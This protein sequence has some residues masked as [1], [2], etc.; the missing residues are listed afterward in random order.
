MHIKEHYNIQTLIPLFVFTNRQ[1]GRLKNN[2]K[3]KVKFFRNLN[4]QLKRKDCYP[5]QIVA[6]EFDYELLLSVHPELKILSPYG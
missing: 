1:K 5:S 3:G 2:I 6:P 4:Q